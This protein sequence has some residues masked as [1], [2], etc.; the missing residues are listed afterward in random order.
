MFSDDVTING[1]SKIVIRPLLE[2]DVRHYFKS[3]G[4]LR[5]ESGFYNDK[6]KM[7]MKT[8]QRNAGTYCERCGRIFYD[9]Q[10]DNVFLYKGFMICESCAKDKEL[11]RPENSPDLEDLIKIRKHYGYKN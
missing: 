4:R 11:K 6:G 3:L 7:Q 1:V 9:T 10:L 8:I 2:E 5:V